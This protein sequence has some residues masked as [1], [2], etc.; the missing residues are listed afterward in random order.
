VTRWPNVAALRHKNVRYWTKASAEI[1]VALVLDGSGTSQTLS[2][3]LGYS[4]TTVNPTLRFL[5]DWKAVRRTGPKYVIDWELRTA[6]APCFQ[7][8]VM[9]HAIHPLNREH[10]SEKIPGLV[11]VF[12]FVRLGCS[13]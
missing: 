8:K 4:R 3:G 9:Y 10:L 13:E 6:L 12:N 11:E 1:F 7:A 2:E 5:S